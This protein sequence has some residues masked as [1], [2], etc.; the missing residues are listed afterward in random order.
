MF[1]FLLLF[2][3]KIL[4]SHLLSRSV[5]FLFYFI[6]NYKSTIINAAFHII[7]S[8]SCVCSVCFVRWFIWM[9]RIRFDILS[10]QQNVDK[11]LITFYGSYKAK[12]EAKK[13]EMTMRLQSHLFRGTKMYDDHDRAHSLQI[14][15]VTCLYP[16]AMC[17]CSIR[18]NN[19]DVYLSVWEINLCENHLL[20]RWDLV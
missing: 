19:S 14:G 16:R 13:K 1:F 9:R 11:H 15:N 12:N 5:E 20:A 7:F 6:S 8:S 17:V 4:Y 2:L 18:S 3:N 10:H